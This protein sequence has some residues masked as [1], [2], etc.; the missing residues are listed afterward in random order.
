MAKGA[1]KLSKGGGNAG[2]K[3]LYAGLNT[4]GSAAN[5]ENAD[6]IVQG[7]RDVLSDFG[8]D[9]AFR[10]V[11]YGKYSGD[12]GMNAVGDLSI[13][14]EYIAKNKENQRSDVVSDTYYGTGAHEAGHLV[15]SELTRRY[16][17]PNAS[18]LEKA[19][20]RKYD[21]TEKE[22]LKE[23][24]RRFG[25]NP[26]ISKYGSTKPGE[27]VAEAISDVYGNKGRANPYS[28]VIVE[29]LKDIQRGAFRPTITV[30]KREMGI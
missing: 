29:V 18:N 25:S 30:T 26:V 14:N 24:K 28:K 22:V 12:A 21:K 2:K 10:S 27:K 5:Q 4:E 8:V 20:A 3:D 6:K 9:D 7:A 19:S 13:S 1:S 11:R 16:L 17:M 15:V 23:A